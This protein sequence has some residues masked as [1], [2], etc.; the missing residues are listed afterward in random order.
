M[1]YAIAFIVAFFLAT[2]GVS[3]M[4]YLEVLEVTPDF[5]LIFVASWAIVRGRDEAM[6]VVPMAGLLRDLTTS[7]P[8]GTS[9]LGLAPI[10][11]LLVAVELMTEEKGF[12]PAVAVVGFGTVTFGVISMIVLA[13]TGQ[14]MAW[15]DATMRVVI[16]SAI[17]NA[18]FTPIVY[19]PVR[20]LS[21]PPK[22]GAAEFAKAMPS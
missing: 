3:A 4:P 1:K 9:V 2:L 15:W 11:L 19:L 5:V 21:P 16:P 7:D 12:V 6:V 20:W 14:E 13:S 17:V 8:I 22:H 18:L 10:V